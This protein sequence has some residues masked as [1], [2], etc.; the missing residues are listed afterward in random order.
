MSDLSPYLA[1]DPWI[2]TDHPAIVATARRLGSARAVY[3]FV[4]DQ[5]AHSWDI[6]AAR[7]TATASEVLSAG[8]GICY[9]KSHLLAALLRARGIPS[10]IACQRLLLF[11]DPAD[12]Y[13]LHTLNTAFLEGRWVRLD[14]RGNKPG[15]DARFPEKDGIER[16][17]FAVRPAR[18]EIDYPQNFASP[19]VAITAALAR[20]GGLR[21]L[22]R[23]HLPSALDGAN[24][25]EG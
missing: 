18:G 4:R 20:G 12:G 7:V 2:E 14:A 22:Y 3:T 15:V 1:A 6:Q 5:I 16:L 23:C 13:S 11:D 19:P 24:R 9:A 10:G 17:A 8:H 25:G 21:D